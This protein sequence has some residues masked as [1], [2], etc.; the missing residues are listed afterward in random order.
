MT[1]SGALDVPAGPRTTGDSDVLRIEADLRADGVELD[2][3]AVPAD[4][5]DDCETADDYRDVIEAEMER[6]E[7]RHHVVALANCR[8]DTLENGPGEGDR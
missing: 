3:P 1:D 8:I 6:D 4:V 2:N 5:V 7:T